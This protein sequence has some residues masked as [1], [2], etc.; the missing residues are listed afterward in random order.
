MTTETGEDCVSKKPWSE[1]LNRS[2][3]LFTFNLARE[4]GKSV[5]R[6]VFFVIL[7]L[8]ALMLVTYV[9]DSFTGWFS[10]WFDIWPFNRGDE[11]VVAEQA[12]PWWKFGGEESAAAPAADDG[13]KW[14]CKFNPLC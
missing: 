14:Y 13:E 4:G 6:V 7:G 2:L 3:K 9:V 1:V 12:S 10:S 5:G 8:I 11:V